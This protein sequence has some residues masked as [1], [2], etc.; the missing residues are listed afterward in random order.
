[1][2]QEALSQLGQ[3]CQVI[4]D[5]LK[6]FRDEFNRDEKSIQEAAGHFL[7]KERL[8]DVERLHNQFDIQLKN[9]HDLRH[10]YEALQKQLQVVSD[11][12]YINEKKQALKEE[13]ATLEQTLLGLRNEFENFTKKLSA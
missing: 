13:Y 11:D 1:M 10:A 3:E 9:I 7:S 12:N 2:N 5:R 8:V 4:I 6:E